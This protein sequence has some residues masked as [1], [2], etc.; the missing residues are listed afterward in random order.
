[1]NPRMAARRPWPEAEVAEQ[2]SPI[3]EGES[4]AVIANTLDRVRGSACKIVP[5]VWAYT[6]PQVSEFR[7]T[8]C[9]SHLVTLHARRLKTGP[10]GG[11]GGC[12]GSCKDTPIEQRIR[13]YGER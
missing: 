4:V 10:V 13:L 8:A 1:M 2:A 12:F 5:A 7:E 3:A 11:Q 9:T 6:L